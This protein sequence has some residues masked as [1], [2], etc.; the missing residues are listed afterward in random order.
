MKEAEG[1]L[2]SETDMRRKGL[3]SNCKNQF[4][5]CNPLTD[6]LPFQNDQNEVWPRLSIEDLNISE[7]ESI[8]TWA[9]RF[10]C[11]SAPF[12]PRC[13][14]LSSCTPV[15]P[16]ISAS[17]QVYDLPISFK[18]PIPQPPCWL[19]DRG[20]LKSSLLPW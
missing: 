16:H 14:S 11:H 17:F 20:P 13:R 19:Q 15:C 2:P 6:M 3:V 5:A 9:L 8:F 12:Y 10:T 7:C 18:I 4:A 1:D